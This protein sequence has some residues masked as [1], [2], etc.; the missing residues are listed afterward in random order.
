MPVI[1]RVRFRLR[2]KIL[3]F[4]LFAFGFF[5]CLISII[6]LYLLKRVDDTTDF[7]FDNIGV[8]WWSCVETNATIGVACFMT[9]KPLLSRWFPS[10]VE[11]RPSASRMIAVSDG[12][13]PTIG[14]RPMRLRP[15]DFQPSLTASFR[16]YE[17]VAEHGDAGG[18]NA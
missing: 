6:R 11:E 8:A 13:L 18:K 4:V 10:I 17:V 1:F 3:L 2:Q 15:A 12:R 16:G 9:M 14:S 5:I 7:T